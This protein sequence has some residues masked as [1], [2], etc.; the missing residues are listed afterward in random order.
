MQQRTG[1]KIYKE[2][3][4]CKLKETQGECGKPVSS[5]QTKFYRQTWFIF[6]QVDIE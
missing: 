1:L 3:S 6:K 2:M 5:T 4:F